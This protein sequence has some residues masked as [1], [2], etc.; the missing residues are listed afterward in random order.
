MS[1]SLQQHM[2]ETMHTEF[3]KREGAWLVWCDP[4]GH[5]LPLLQRVFHS[6]ALKE[7]DIPFLS[8]TEYTAGELGSPTTR[9]E[10]QQE[11][12]K[13]HAFVLYVPTTSE[14][15]GWLW[16]QTL[17]AEHIF[18]KSLRDQLLDWGWKPQSILTSVEVVA[19][20]ARQHLQDDPAEWGG[21]KIQPQPQYLLNILAGG[22]VVS[23][24]DEDDSSANDYTVLDLTI[25]EAGLPRLELPLDATGRYNIDEQA[26]ERW[27]IQCVARLLMTHTQQ[28]VP[29]AIRAHEYLISA[30]KR[31]FALDLIK[32]WDDSLKLRRGL[33][34]RVLE[35][36]RLLS[37]GNFLGEANIHHGPFLSHAAERTLIAALCQRL[38]ESKDRALLENL[39][40]LYEDLNRHA[41]GFWGDW[42]ERPQAQA[43]PWGELTRL[44]K[45][46]TTLLDATPRSPW[47]KPA[48]AI[49]W[50]IH[51]G[52]R[53][54]QAGEQILQHLT[55]TSKELLDL[56]TP[57]REAYRNHWEN[58]MIEWSDV[59]SNAGYPV[60]GLKSQGEWLKEELSASSRPTAVIVIDALRYDIGVALKHLVNESEGMERAQVVA[61]R[62]AL[63]TITALGMGM[64][65]PLAEND[66]YAE[67]V[68]GKWQL[69]QK[70][71]TLDLSSA[72]NRR[73]WI[74]SNYKIAPDALLPLADVRA[75]GIV[76][77]PQGKQPLL[78][79]FDAIIDKLGHDEEL[80]A[81]GTA[82]IQKNYV[83]TIELLRDNEWE[84]VLIVT[85]HGFIHW[86]GTLERKVSPVPD[87]AYSSR[88]AM[89]YPAERHLD[90]PQ[91]LAPG[92]KWR[93][94]VPSGAACFRTYGGLGFFHG[95]ASL[96]EWI[97]PCIKITWPT[98][99]RPVTVTMQRI[100][101]ILSLRQRIVL[102]VQHEGL[103]SDNSVLSRQVE[104][105]IRDSK[106]QTILFKGKPKL[107]KPEEG[108]VAVTI[109]PLDDVE[110]ARNTPLIIELH[111]ARTNEVLDSQTSALMVALENW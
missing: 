103:F 10:V 14:S 78:F 95:G 74:R 90:G 62:T 88:R 20:L 30:E 55:K 107:I 29:N 96:Q 82:A 54:E 83:E 2:I 1:R 39:V 108:P 13:K 111:D 73:E 91:G 21:D 87:A 28:L 69:S 67:I 52:W 9:R 5:W 72:E 48:D 97:V 19:Q 106:Q 102:E 53:V 25:E 60:P 40:P 66:L 36:D 86:P 110:A 50:Y 51:V 46:A 15:L 45:A 27:R 63:P 38:M 31:A 16:S 76:P 61:A 105:V 65:L 18:E 22:S 64:A 75:S 68:K 8:I 59:W 41:H 49:E 81:M 99:A 35:A 43:L 85:D 7:K 104:I 100:D 94:A 12:D 89:A 37:L 32:R 33:P 42:A 57:L 4:Q 3:R 92:G 101:K 98:K 84:R 80:E 77:K 109:E 26:L 17:L 71:Q 70:G 58:L 47:A 93:I 56:I 34:A 24:T 23:S 11:I 6:A 44:S 79:L